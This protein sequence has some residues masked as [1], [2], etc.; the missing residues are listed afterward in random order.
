MRTEPRR[1]V[2]DGRLGIRTAGTPVSFERFYDEQFDAMV[3]VAFFVVGSEEAA[4]EVV[5]DAFMRLYHRWADLDSPGGYL[6][7]TVVNGCRD[8]L[9]RR[10]RF[11][12]RLTTIAATTAT[13]VV[14]GADASADRDELMRALAA[15]PIRTRTALVLRFYGG[16]TERETAE[17]MGVAIGT[18][19]SSVHRG[20]EQLRKEIA[21]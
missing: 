3:R 18:V 9:R 16:Y 11:D 4:E 20:L 19:K 6:R 7:T 2:A 5:Q 14:A 13:H 12:R 21:P 17:A 1:D 15:L 10:H 8:R